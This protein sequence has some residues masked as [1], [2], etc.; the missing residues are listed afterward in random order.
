[1]GEMI[2]ENYFIIL[3]SIVIQDMCV[4]GEQ[5]GTSTEYES[6]LLLK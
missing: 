5:F 6:K 2:Y 3:S 4:K 1:M